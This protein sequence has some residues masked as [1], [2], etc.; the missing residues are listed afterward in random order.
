MSPGGRAGASR[1]ARWPALTRSDVRAHLLLLAAFAASRVA[2]YAA[3]LR[4]KLDLSWMFLSEPADLRERLLETVF[5]F[6][7]FA[8]GMDVLTGVLLQLAPGQLGAGAAL[9]FWASGWLLCASL[10]ELL[11]ELG[12]GRR[13][14]FAVAL[15]FSLLPQSL[16][17][18]NLYLYTHLCTALLCAGSVAFVRA[19]RRGTT[20][21]WLGF[22]AVCAVLGW[23][24][25]TFHLLWFCLMG[26]GALAACGPGR[27]WRVVTGAALPFALLFGLYL[28]NQLVFGVFGSTS[29]GGA[30]LTLATTQK[31]PAAERAEWIRVGKLS[32]FA[33]INVFAPP[34]DYLKFLPAD[35][36]F[37]WPGSNELWRP[38][39][40]A[41][42]YNHGLYLEVNRR[43]RD[44][45]MTYIEANPWGYLGNVL[46]KNMVGFFSPTTRWHPQD[47]RASSPHHQHRQVLGPY[48]RLYESVVHG[49]P[50][51]VGLYA[52]LPLFLIWAGRE[53]HRAWRSSEPARRQRGL[54]LAFCL[55]QVVFITSVSCLFSSLESARYRYAIE[56]QIWAIVAAGLG[57]LA[58]RWRAYR[59]ATSAAA[60]A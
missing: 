19:A 23:L 2:L 5:Y 40:N 14:A 18:E 6:H 8:P 43:R 52:L 39:V 21:G 54:M 16:F 1:A 24:Y 36:H 51:R 11:G 42:N 50:P 53:C 17:L 20:L 29:W 41:G 22:F 38:S 45:S 32:P 27:R 46:G 56:P 60:A 9:L 47:R 25:T 33:G 30:N 55:F 58:A 26:A 15:S 28:K 7:A 37:P 3:G 4:F 48:E 59:A 10:F 12:L 35:L 49:A 31:M 57:A 44:D 13:V 34:R